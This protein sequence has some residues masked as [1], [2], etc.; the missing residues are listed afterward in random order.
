ME[1]CVLASCQVWQL[2]TLMYKKDSYVT[3][4]SPSKIAIKGT[5]NLTGAAQRYRAQQGWPGQDSKC[6]WT[7]SQKKTLPKNTPINCIFKTCQFL[8]PFDSSATWDFSLLHWCPLD[9]FSLFWRDHY[10]PLPFD[11]ISHHYLHFTVWSFL[12]PLPPTKSMI[13]VN[14]ARLQAKD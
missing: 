7:P 12:R 3:V 6:S 14:S 10:L 9:I 2:G 8:M 1:Y 5:R 13:F 4:L 11:L